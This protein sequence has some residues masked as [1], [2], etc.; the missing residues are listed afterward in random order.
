MIRLVYPRMKQAR[1]RRVILNNIGNGG[2][3]CD[4][5]CIEGAAGN[6]SIMAITRALGGRSLRTI[7]GSLV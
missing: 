5:A 3:I 4:P 7:S 1:R 6:A 2:E